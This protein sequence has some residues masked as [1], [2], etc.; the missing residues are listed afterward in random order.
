MS[1]SRFLSFSLTVSLL[2]PGSGFAATMVP[3]TEPQ[4]GFVKGQDPEWSAVHANATASDS[5]HRL[6]HKNAE[7]ARLSWL[8]QHEGLKGSLA[9]VSAQRAFVRQRNLQHRQWHL[10]SSDPLKVDSAG[11]AALQ[12]FTS[13]TEAVIVEP[14]TVTVSRTMI[15]NPPSRRAIVEAAEDRN[16][17]RAVSIGQF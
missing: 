16:K 17:V 13:N 9:Y 1:T 10:Q 3:K 14:A 7:A 4:N 5:A 15:G 8:Q 11:S 12:I 6:Y 2:F